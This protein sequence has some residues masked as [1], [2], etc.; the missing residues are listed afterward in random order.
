MHAGPA[1]GFRTLPA[2]LKA[3]ARAAPGAPFVVFDDLRGRVTTRTYREFD[4]TPDDRHLVVMP[5]FHG[6]A[7]YYSTMSALVAGASVALMARFSASRYF[8]R[9]IAHR[10]TVSSLFAA[11]IRMLLAQPRR[12]ELAANDLRVV[13]FADDRAIK[14]AGVLPDRLVPGPARRLPRPAARAVPGGAAAHGGRQDPEARPPR[15]GRVAVFPLTASTTAC[16]T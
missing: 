6:N 5:L 11:P 13:I 7:Q 9:A 12:P 16:A 3:R 4:R 14:H 2:L 15:G 8:D 1:A 10:C